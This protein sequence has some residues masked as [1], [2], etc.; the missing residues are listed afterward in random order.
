[1]GVRVDPDGSRVPA[2]L[3]VDVLRLDGALRSEAEVLLTLSTKKTGPLGAVLGQVTAA[4]LKVQGK[5]GAVWEDTDWDGAICT[6]G[7]LH[8]QLARKRSGVGG[9]FGVVATHSE[10]AHFF[11]ATD[12]SLVAVARVVDA[13]IAVVVPWYVRRSSYFIFEKAD[14]SP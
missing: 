10:A 6:D 14:G 11:V 12:G 1:M 5:S 2:N 7:R 3:V 4:R 13:G 9:V 8:F